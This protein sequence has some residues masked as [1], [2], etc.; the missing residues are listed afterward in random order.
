LLISK[1]TC[2]LVGASQAILIR[3]GTQTAKFYGKTVATEQF[4]CSYGLAPEYRAQVAA[5]EL[6]VAAVGGEDEARVVEL[7]RHRFSRLCIYR[8]FHPLLG[9]PIRSSWR[10][11]APRHDSKDKAIERRL[12]GLNLRTEKLA[13]N[14]PG[15]NVC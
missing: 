6:Q 1:L 15:E 13:S 12:L 7:P 3:A 5:G 2:S 9:I 14:L 11:C 10:S 4:R 8:S